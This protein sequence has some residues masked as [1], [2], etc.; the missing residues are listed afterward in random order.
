MIYSDVTITVKGNTATLDNDL[1]LYKNDKNITI[2][3]SIVNSIWNFA[4]KL[5]NNIIEKTEATIF[6]LRWMKGDKV[7]KVFED[8]Q[9]KKGKC[10]F[11]ITE[12]LIDEDIEM[13]D[14]DFQISLLD[15]EKN[16]ILSIPPVI[17][18][19]HINKHIFEDEEVITDTNEVNVATVGLAKTTTGEAVSV[20]DDEGNYIKTEWLDGDVIT[21]E[22]LNKIE[23]GIYNN[24][25]QCK[26]I[27][28]KIDEIA[29]S[30]GSGGSSGGTTTSDYDTEISLPFTASKDTD[31]K[32]VFSKGDEISNPSYTNEV[33][34]LTEDAFT[35]TNAGAGS[36][37]TSQVIEDNLKCMKVKHTE[38]GYVRVE[39]NSENVFGDSK[40]FCYFKF[41][42]I[43]DSAQSYNPSPIC[44]VATNLNCITGFDGATIGAQFDEN[45]TDWQELCCA[46]QVNQI[47][48][49][50]NKKVSIGFA[51]VTGELYIN[52]L[53]LV[54]L[55]E[56][57][58]E[59][60]TK[61]ELLEMVKDGQFDNNKGGSTTTTEFSCTITNGSTTEEIVPFTDTGVTKYYTVTNGSTLSIAKRTGYGMPSVQALIKSTS[62]VEI[63]DCEL[64]LNTRFKGKK[65]IFEGDSITDYDYLEEYNNKSWANYLTT[66]LGMNLVSN[67]AVGGSLLTHSN[68]AEGYSVQQRVANTNYDNDTRLFLIHAGTNDWSQAKTLGDIDSTD[69][70]TLCGALNNIIDKIQTNCPKATIV[71]ISPIHRQDDNGGFTLNTA[72]YSLNDIAIAYEKVCKRWGVKFKNGLELGLNTLNAKSLEDNYIDGLHPAPKGHKTMAV[73]MA[74]EINTY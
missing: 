47:D 48:A 25:S 40:W 44:S 50:K 13:G 28:H 26:D 19:I 34:S 3:I 17:G 55:T 66:I 60:K 63:E 33:A 61:N 71:I 36:Y 7:K 29:S 41:K 73:E 54:N 72:S 31:V 65:V 56:E 69:I 23:E 18:Q 14:Y 32:V 52:K 39:S 10:E 70:S 16:S 11:V 45:S 6:T 51:N 8:Q 35:F 2:N 22:K 38:N 21:K 43:K 12:E 57:G 9:I 1:Y 64:K 5:E 74:R 58:L 30:G 62:T 4:K 20:V 24:S 46:G 15:E 67:G 27:A 37:V 53:I 68:E 42:L 49:Y 59:S